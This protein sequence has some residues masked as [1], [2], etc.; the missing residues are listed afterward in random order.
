MFNIEYSNQAVKFLKKADK[1]LAR[2][3]LEKIEELKS[4]PILHDSKSIE[5]YKE[6][7]FR[8]RIGDYR[9]IYEV[10]YTN[11]KIGIVRIDKRE[12]VY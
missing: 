6:K 8:V 5:G 9:A 10:D 11:N 1:N 4:Q 2:R 7:L 12:S 3:I